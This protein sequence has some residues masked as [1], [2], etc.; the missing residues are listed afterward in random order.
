MCGPALA[1]FFSHCRTAVVL[2]VSSGILQIQEARKHGMHARQ[3]TL[4]RIL[5]FELSFP[6]TFGRGSEIMRK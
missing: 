4:Y 2:C 5:S 6:L 1:H 3:Q